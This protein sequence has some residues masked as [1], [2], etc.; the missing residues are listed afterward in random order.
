M[1]NCDRLRWSTVERT[2]ATSWAIWAED[3]EGGAGGRSATMSPGV[4]SHGCTSPKFGSIGGRAGISRL[5][6]GISPWATALSANACHWAGVPTAFFMPSAPARVRKTAATDFPSAN[7]AAISL[8]VARPD[9]NAALR[10]SAARSVISATAAG[11]ST[12]SIS[13]LTPERSEEHTSEL[14]SP[15]YLVCRLLLE[16]KK[17]KIK[18]QK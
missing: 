7:P 16:K 18:K 9:Q 13:A 17:I 10:C 8:A 3:V 4:I 15:M 6:Q 14:Q 5:F 11:K 1:A 2:S 12:L